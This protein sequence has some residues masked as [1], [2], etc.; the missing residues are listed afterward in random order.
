MAKSN[1]KY[2]LL[3]FLINPSALFD[4]HKY[5]Y[6]KKESEEYL[7]IPLKVITL[8]IAI[9]GLFAMAFEERNCCIVLVK[10]ALQ[11]RVR[12]LLVF[13]SFFF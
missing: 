8:L 6:I 10:A 13:S 9:S 7:V 4:D 12:E 1:P 2:S 11:Q 3:N 5:E